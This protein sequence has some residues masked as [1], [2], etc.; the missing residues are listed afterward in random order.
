MYLP[1]FN[2]ELD[3][4]GKRDQIRRW[5]EEGQRK[6]GH[7]DHTCEALVF[8]M[9]AARAL[10]DILLTEPQGRAEA[11]KHWPAYEHWILH[12]FGGMQNAIRA[13]QSASPS[14]EPP[15]DVS[16]Q[17]EVYHRFCKRFNLTDSEQTRAGY[18]KLKKQSVHDAHLSVRLEG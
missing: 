1:M 15:E 18:L 8:I 16:A 9:A 5:L 6:W 7:D 4:Q 11:K 14:G 17:D 12:D 2:E 13:L 10:L 3:W